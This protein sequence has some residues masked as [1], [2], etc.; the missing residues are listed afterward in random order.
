MYEFVLFRF[1]IE[2]FT[3]WQ[4]ITVEAPIQVEFLILPSQELI[5]YILTD[6]PAKP[7]IVYM[8]QGLERFKLK[9]EMMSLSRIRNMKAF[10]TNDGNSFVSAANDKGTTLIRSYFRGYKHG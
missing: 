7:L 6:N 10:N 2:K 5:L 8:Y 4:D 9:H 1:D 3:H